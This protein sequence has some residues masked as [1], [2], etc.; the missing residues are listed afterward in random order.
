MNCCKKF[1]RA[2]Y[3][4]CD[5]FGKIVAKTFMKQEGYQLTSEVEAYK[6]HDLIF[7]KDGK[8]CKVEVEMNLRWLSKYYPY[9]TLTVP[10]RKKDSKADFYIMISKNGGGLLTIPMQ[11]VLS[12]NIIVKD[13][14]FTK[15]EKFFSLPISK[16]RIYFLQDGY[17]Y[18]IEDDNEIF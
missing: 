6:S 16:A 14:R 11:E 1:D 18:P 5:T 4:E 8:D 3:E 7:T 17:Y 15:Q 12:A 10:Y 2:L 9:Q 13:T